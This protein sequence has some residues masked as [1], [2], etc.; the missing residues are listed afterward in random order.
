M[1]LQRNLFRARLFVDTVAAIAFLVFLLTPR[2][3][4]QNDQ[5]ICVMTFNLWQGGEEGKQPLEQSV[6][7]I[8]AAK[9]DLVGLQETGGLERDG[10]RPDNGR[11]IAEQLGWNY[12]AQKDGTGIASRY[13]IARHSPAKLGICVQ[14]PSGRDVWL[15][16]IHFAHAPYQPYQLLKIPYA[17]APFIDGAEQAVLEAH[18]ARGRQV[19]ALLADIKSVRN[20]KS[21]ILI[22]GD[23]NEPSVLDWTDAV[24]RAGR[25]PIPVRWPTTAAVLAAGFTD[26]YHQ[27][28]PDPLKRP[29]YTW[30]PITAVDDPKDRHDRIDFVFAGRA[31]KVSKTEIVGERRESADVLVTPYP[32]DH[33]AVAATVTFDN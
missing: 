6:K 14:L 30:T 23:F 2:A 24:H 3:S 18:K 11:R 33:R 17:D 21:V 7:V 5:A 28:F 19:S 9:A 4:A 13:K 8:A 22:T 31:A 20:P 16:N 26:A 1:S 15:F 12:F 27:T 29:G 25:C 10:K 32:S